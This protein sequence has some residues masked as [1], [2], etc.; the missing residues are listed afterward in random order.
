[1][2]SFQI[3]IFQQIQRETVVVD[4][5][6]VVVPAAKPAVLVFLIILFLFSQTFILLIDRRVISLLVTNQKGPAIFPA[7]VENTLAGIQTVG[8]YFKIRSMGNCASDVSS[9]VLLLFVPAL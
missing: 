4:P 7:D 8:A 6:N 3:A 5:A 9:N 1:M 2:F